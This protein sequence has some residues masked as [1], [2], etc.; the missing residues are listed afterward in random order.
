MR[1][2]L[3]VG[4]NGSASRPSSGSRWPPSAPASTSSTPTSSR[5]GAGPTIPRPTPTR[6]RALPPR[7]ARRSL[8]GASRSSPR[9]CS[10]TPRSSTCCGR[11]CRRATTAR[12]TCSWSP[13]S[14]PSPG[15]GP[16][17]RRWPRRPR[18]KDPGRY[19]RLWPLVADAIGLADT[20]TVYDNLDADG[21]L[22]VAV[23]SHG[24][25][26]GDPPWPDWAPDALTPA[27]PAT[28]SQSDASS[29]LL[30]YCGLVPPRRSMI[31]TTP[32]RSPTRWSPGW[33]G[34]GLCPGRSSARQTC[35]A[36]MPSR[37][38]PRTSGSQESPTNTASAASTPKARATGVDVRVRLACAGR[39]PR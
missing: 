21:P 14:W 34:G 20:A 29:D 7:H 30:A 1:L 27:G 31:S 38:G 32:V 22:S 18:G 8:R 16:G 28:H 6:R 33:S 26:S 4:P 37:R 24:F 36:V 13:R 19:Q 3:V 17:R 25:P 2:D 5:S 15:R 35:T 12:S 23:L 9:P 39:A 11:R 10:P